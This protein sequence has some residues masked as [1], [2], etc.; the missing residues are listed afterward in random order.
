MAEHPRVE[1][2]SGRSPSGFSVSP[3][4]PSPRAPA[5]TLQASLGSRAAA[6]IPRPASRPPGVPLGRWE[7][8]PRQLEQ[9]SGARPPRPRLGSWAHPRTSRNGLGVSST[10]HPGWGRGPTLGSRAHTRALGREKGGGVPRRVLSTVGGK[11]GIRAGPGPATTGRPPA[12][13]RCVPT[14]HVPGLY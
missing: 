7:L 2:V 9:T 3:A 8:L 10:Y 12:S 4:P 5:P 1:P 11:E 14:S 13:P 6:R